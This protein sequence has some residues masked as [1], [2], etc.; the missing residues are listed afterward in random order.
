MSDFVDGLRQAVALTGDPE[1]R[2]TLGR[3]IGVSGLATLGAMLVGVPLG[4]L[5]GRSRFRGRSVLVCIVN[6]GM[7]LPSVVVGLVVWLLLSR[8]GPFGSLELIYTKTAMVVAQFVLATPIVIGVTSAAVQALPPDLPDLLRT[9]G[10]GPLRT[11]WLI[12][13]EVRLGLLAAVMAAFGAVVSEVG[14]SLTVGGNLRGDTRVLTTAIVTV[15]GR[16]DVAA[17]LTL[18]I[19]LLALAFAVNAVLTAAQQRKR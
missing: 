15:T 3:T 6:T 19:V 1:L 10:A 12:S 14:A 4:Y 8:S 9:L 13:R 16:G 18:G 2:A 7:A 5:L 17:A 11:I